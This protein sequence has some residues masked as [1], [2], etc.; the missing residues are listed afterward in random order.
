MD[1]EWLTDSPQRQTASND[2]LFV[3]RAEDDGTKVSAGFN[4]SWQGRG[5]V[6]IKSRIYVLL[7]SHEK[8]KKEKST[9]SVLSVI[10][11]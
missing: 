8:Q 4:L 2:S 3:L 9:G 7:L 6:K 11:F 10:T 5:T 1:N